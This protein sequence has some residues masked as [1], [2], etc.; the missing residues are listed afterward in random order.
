M[1]LCTHFIILNLI[2]V[3]LQIVGQTMLCELSLPYMIDKNIVSRLDLNLI[4][5]RIHGQYIQTWFSE[6]D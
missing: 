4:I 2:M 1:V 3:L 5:Q 6:L